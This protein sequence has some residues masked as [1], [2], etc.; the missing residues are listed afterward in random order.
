MEDKE[1]TKPSRIA[2]LRE[3]AGLSQTDLSEE[4]GINI[5]QIQKYESGEIKVENMTLK[6][7]FMMAG[8]LGCAVEDLMR[9]EA[10]DKKIN[11]NVLKIKIKK[12]HSEGM[13][14]ERID[15]ENCYQLMIDL[16]DAE[17]WSICLQPGDIKKYKIDTII[18]IPFEAKYGCTV[19]SWNREYTE[20]AI[21]L[22]EDYGWIVEN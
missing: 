9:P 11:E 1:M 18:A 16:S 15:L 7:A 13:N 5:R 6:N 19:A 10:E 22:L 3:R 8:V 2:R 12:A 17:I 4:T 21:K 14:W 20:N